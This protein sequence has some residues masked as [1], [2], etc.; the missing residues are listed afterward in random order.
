MSVALTT[1]LS[2]TVTLILLTGVFQFE[3]YRGRRWFLSGLRRRFDYLITGMSQALGHRHPFGRGF[4]R[5][6]FHY[7]AHTL[8]RRLLAGLRGIEHGVERLIRRNR[9][10]AKA[11]D[12]APKLS[13][14]S[15]HLQQIAEHKV[16][17]ALT[18]REKRRLRAHL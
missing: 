13:E 18:E 7:L 5:L 10:A 3:D 1:L 14:A 17:T 11:L 6:L 2:S 4:L 15:T 12:T 16:E 8:L 9:R